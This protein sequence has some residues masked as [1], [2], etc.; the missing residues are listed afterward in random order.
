MENAPVFVKIEKYKELTGIL[1]QVDRK[2]AQA[3]KMLDQLEHLKEEEDAQLK[4]WATALE[5]VKARAQDL[6]DSLFTNQ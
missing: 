4:A 2:I 5:D 3:S 6:N 1:S